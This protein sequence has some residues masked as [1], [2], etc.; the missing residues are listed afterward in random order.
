M[1]RKSTTLIA[2]AGVLAVCVGGYVGVTQ[3]NAAQ[4]AQQE[5]A[6]TV[7]LS[8]GTLEDLMGVSWSV[9]GYQL[10]FAK[11][12]DAWMYSGDAS[13]PL[14][15]SKLSSAVSGVAPLEVQGPLNGAQELEEYGIDDESD[16]VTLT[17]QDGTQ[18][19]VRF[20]DE[21]PLG[22]GRYCSVD[23]QDGVYLADTGVVSGME[24]EL[25]DLIQF[26]DIPSL[27]NMTQLTLTN[28]SGTIQASQRE[29]P[30]EFYYTDAYDWFTPADEPLDSD[31][32]SALV[33][34]AAGVN[35]LSCAAYGVTDFAPYGLE[36]PAAVLEAVYPETVE[37]SESASA[38][39]S[40]EAQTV[41]KT[42]TLYIGGEAEDGYYAALPGS[43][44]VYVISADTAAELLDQTA[45]ALAPSEP[46]CFA[47]DQAA[48]L[49]VWNGD[50]QHTLEFVRSVVSD[51]SDSTS[52]ETSY[53]IDSQSADATAVN[54]WLTQVNSLTVT[55]T[56]E[57][58]PQGE[59]LFTLAVTPED[60]GSNLTVT[61]IAVDDETAAVQLN[62][63][64]WKTVARSDVQE[65]LDGF[66]ALAQGEDQAASSS[67]SSESQS[68]SASASEQG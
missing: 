6:G 5:A 12:G 9:Q 54:Q 1:K 14:D 28:A 13:F 52:V 58:A 37:S 31:Q 63:F 7:T 48:N 34:T 47:W 64:G 30:L 16:S 57:E 41:D 35:F 27:Y 55:G 49:T 60:G 2:L 67:S 62:E 18:T 33:S 36:E 44:R 53:R 24:K 3:W 8:A 21:N 46:F 10:E 29:N 19:T 17:Q 11:N 51:E 40:E 59:E 42:F 25:L 50:S 22:T 65:I 56:L 45:E 66:D 23:G 20:G 61:G 15:E 39:A 32:M 43:D 68:E 38:S 4:Q 26:E